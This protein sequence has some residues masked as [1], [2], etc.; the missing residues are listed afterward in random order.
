MAKFKAAPIQCNLK[1]SQDDTTST[2]TPLNK[3]STFT[4]AVSVNL[5]S[6]D[7]SKKRAV[8]NEQLKEKEAIK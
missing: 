4:E 8:F 3:K 2:N 7:R 1:S 5:L 6:E